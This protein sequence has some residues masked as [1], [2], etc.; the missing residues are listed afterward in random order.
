[1]TESTYRARR[2]AVALVGAVVAVYLGG[3]TAQILGE[4]DFGAILKTALL[5]GFGAPMVL[6]IVW[7]GRAATIISE[8]G[9]AVRSLRT[10]RIPWADVQDIRVE[11][12]P[13]SW[14]QDSAPKQLVVVYRAG[15]KRVSLPHLTQRNLDRYSLD[16]ETEVEHFREAWRQRRGS[17]W[18][19]V[20]EVQLTIAEMRAYGMSSWW[21]GMIWASIA[22]PLIAVPMLALIIADAMP[23]I[24]GSIVLAL[25]AGVP[26]V[27]FVVGTIVS[28]ALRRRRLIRRTLPQRPGTQQSRTPPSPAVRPM[29]RRPP[30]SGHDVPGAAGRTAQ[31]DHSRS[32]PVP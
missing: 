15:G 11:Q 32:N 24:G 22:L 12:N 31:H 28:R 2:G 6:L 7:I 4:H 10:R 13:A 20:P 27:A 21:V 23:N 26:T 8:R 18:A 19:P 30:R 16:L 17:D 14:I 5:L 29:P 1:M 9:I 3:L 25:L